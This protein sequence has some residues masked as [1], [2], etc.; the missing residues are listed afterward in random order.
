MKKLRSSI[1]IAGRNCCGK[2]LG[3][4]QELF[5]TSLPSKENKHIEGKA[6]QRLHLVAITKPQVS[7]RLTF[8]GG[9]DC[10]IKRNDTQAGTAG[11]APTSSVQVNGRDVKIELTPIL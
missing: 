5:A 11:G 4:N 10:N 3:D 8:D 1:A 7:A 2:Q 9:S 6:V